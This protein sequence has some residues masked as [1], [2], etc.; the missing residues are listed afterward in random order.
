MVYPGV[1][2]EENP[3]GPRTIS[4]VSTSNTAF[5]GFF[6]R[7]PM[8]EPVRIT[9]FSDFERRFG[10]LDARSEAS[11]AIQQYYLNGGSIALVV[12]VAERAPGVVEG[13]V[14][15]GDALIAGMETLDK[16]SFNILSLPAAAN[17]DN[18]GMDTVYSAAEAFCEAR[19]AFLIV[20]IPETVDSVNAV[21]DSTSGW[22]TSVGDG[23]RHK[24]AAVYFPRLE[25][26]DSL[27]ENRPRNVGSSG[28]LAGI[29]ARTDSTRGVWKAPAG[30]DASIRGARLTVKL[31]DPENGALNPLGVNVLRD[32]PS[33][34][35][36]AWGARTLEGADRQFSEWRY[37]PVRRTALFIEESLIQGLKWFVFEPNDEPL[38]AQIRISVA[39]FMQGLFRQGAL[40]GAS[41]SE[42]YF[43]KCDKETTTQNDIALGVI[44]IFGGFSLLK[45]AEFIIIKIQQIAGQTGS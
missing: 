32:F 2:V 15:D 18:A 12:R 14:P 20:D 13:D 19:R 44:N 41:P 25:I 5:V 30:T 1:Y 45:P 7:G 3:N 16:I 38:W 37:I 34:G 36:V 24:N 39:A 8:N 40:Q 42:A 4:G 22:L 28:T 6:T 43:V 29:F 10:G 23:L 35:S 17:L 31:T 27:N 21:I 33:I 9:S 26:S 11:Y